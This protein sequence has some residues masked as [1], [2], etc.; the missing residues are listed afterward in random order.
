MINSLE[1]DFK[2]SCKSL[3]TRKTMM[4][5]IHLVVFTFWV[6][7]LIGQVQIGSDILGEDLNDDFGSGLAINEDGTIVAIGVHNRNSRNGIVEVYE[8]IDGTWKLLGSK[9]NGPNNSGFGVDVAISPSGKRLIIGSYHDNI[10]RIY[11]FVN[12]N[13]FMTGEITLE[14][15]A[16]A[17]HFGYAVDISPDGRT[18]AISA[19]HHPQGNIHR[20]LVNIYREINSQWI[21]LGDGIAG[22]FEGDVAGWDIDLAENGNTIII[23]SAGNDTNGEDAGQVRIFKFNNSTWNQIGRS[24]H[25]EHPHLSFGKS[26]DISEDGKNLIVGAP[27]DWT[28]TETEYHYAEVF[29]LIN[30][31]WS[32]KGKKIFGHKGDN[33]GYDVA[34]SEDG[35]R[36]AV[37][38]T[39][40]KTC[41][42]RIYD[43]IDLDWQLVGS[44]SH[45]ADRHNLGGSLAMNPKGDVII[46]TSR[47]PDG[48]FAVVYDLKDLQVPNCVKEDDPED[49]EENDPEVIEI[50]DI[51]FP[52]AIRFNSISSENSVFFG[53]SNVEVGYS[54][55]ILD[56]WGSLVF[57]NQNAITNSLEAGW[58][59][60][61]ESA[62][63]VYVYLVK[64]YVNEKEE[65]KRGYITLLK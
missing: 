16:W 17:I 43:F 59:P 18:V 22:E 21:Q 38:V 52:N 62:Q 7:N 29:E 31:D 60:T 44:I 33:M 46:G 58:K 63:G 34:I 61:T 3:A 6:W 13:W 14:M 50:R 11:D 55:T 37:T 2:N 24:L 51:F 26:V 48:G 12:N 23:G 53:K 65:I 10:T 57:E 19:T 45:K 1:K 36:I 9:I 32:P 30:E 56:R 8:L 64:Y 41:P 25:G 49:E 5:Y 54:I 42:I 15:A 40:D 20:G 28:G 4:K 27:I 39:Q 47:V 35:N